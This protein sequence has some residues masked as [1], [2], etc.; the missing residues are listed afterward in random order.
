MPQGQRTTSDVGD[1]DQDCCEVLLE[2][3]VSGLDSHS[4]EQA[5][6]EETS[7]NLVRLA[8]G[9][10]FKDLDPMEASAGE[11]IANAEI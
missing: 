5:A 10:K 6:N 3:M 9:R 2:S 11:I 1:I 7:A 4:A 8:A